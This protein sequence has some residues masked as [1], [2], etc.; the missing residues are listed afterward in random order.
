MGLLPPWNYKFLTYFPIAVSPHVPRLPI[1]FLFGWKYYA[2]VIPIRFSVL[3]I[4][5]WLP[6]DHDQLPHFSYSVSSHTSYYSVL[7]F[8]IVI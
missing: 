6:S 7:L 3:P 2:K 4:T 8:V 1:L 5:L